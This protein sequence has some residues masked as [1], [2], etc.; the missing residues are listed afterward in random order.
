M[1][2][3]LPKKKVVF[4]EEN[5]CHSETQ[6]MHVTY[7]DKMVWSIGFAL[8]MTLLMLTYT[9]TELSK[10]CDFDRDEIEG[11]EHIVRVP[12]PGD[13]DDDFIPDI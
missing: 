4:N 2:D 8:L 9:I 1:F 6:A 13:Y 11:Q 7:G 5:E 3:S 12:A 10:P